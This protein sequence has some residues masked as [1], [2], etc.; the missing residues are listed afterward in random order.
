M[1]RKCF[2]L[3]FLLSVAS[4]DISVYEVWA[5]APTSAKIAYSSWRD[6]NMDIYLMNPD[7]NEGVR[8]THHLARDAG[9]QWS[10]TGERILFTSDRDGAPGSWDLYLMD[11]DGSNVRRVFEKEAARGVPTWSPDGKQIAYVRWEQGKF[12]IYIA[13]I[14]GK[15]EERIALGSLPAWSPDGTEIAFSVGAPSNPKRIS[16]LDVRT[17]KHKFFFPPKGPAWVRHPVWSPEGDRLAFAWYNRVELRQE[18]FKLETVYIINRDGTG[19]Q[20]IIEEGKGAFEPLWSPHGD[21]LL[22]TQLN[23]NDKLQIFKVALGGGEPVQLTNPNFPHF[24]GDWFDPAFA[25]PVA[26]QPQLLTTQWGQVKIR[27]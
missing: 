13:P 18:D 19:L 24:L 4:L 16:M 26:P 20:Q 3:L 22:Y 23:K 11:A 8:L 9:P 6:G 25:L 7:G 14:D 17:R 27:N 21:E 5:G 2:F 1:K 12:F 10:P 15:K